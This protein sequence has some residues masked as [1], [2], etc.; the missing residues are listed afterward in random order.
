MPLDSLVFSMVLGAGVPNYPMLLRS[1]LLAAYR[2]LHFANF[3]NSPFFVPE[4]QSFHS[5]ALL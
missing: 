2:R 4:L 3:Q 1:Y 5:K